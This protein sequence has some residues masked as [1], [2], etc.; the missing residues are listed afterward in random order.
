MKKLGPMIFVGLSVCFL[1]GCTFIN[2]LDAKIPRTVIPIDKTFVIEL[3]Y[4]NREIIRKEIHCEKY[5]DAMASVRGNYWAVR[6]V[7]L[8]SQYQTSKIIIHDNEIGTI[9]FPIPVS[10]DLVESKRTLLKHLPLTINGKTF[11][12][13]SSK[14][15]NHAYF[16]PAMHNNGIYESVTLN[17]TLKVNGIT[18][19]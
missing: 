6:E 2:G 12:F 13:K 17:F 5:Y 10:E 4:Q 1:V 11:W 14:G 15:S 8:S 16:R 18:L 3:Q 7:G 9:E 19:E